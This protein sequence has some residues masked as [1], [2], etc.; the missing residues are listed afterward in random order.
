MRYLVDEVSLPIEVDSAGT[1][2]SAGFPPL[3][4]IALIAKQRGYD[5]GGLASRRIRDEDFRQGTYLLAVDR[6]THDALAMLKPGQSKARLGLLTAYAEVFPKEDLCFPGFPGFPDSGGVHAMAL[7]C[8][9]V[10]DACLGLLHALH[11]EHAL[12]DEDER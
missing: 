1:H 2:A 12:R 10:E 7:V 8:D 6:E 11:D 5:A 9:R 4:A 3:A